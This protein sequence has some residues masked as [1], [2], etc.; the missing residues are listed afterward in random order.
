MSEATESGMVQMTIDGKVGQFPAGMTILEAA[1]NLGIDIPTLCYSEAV[2]QYGACRLCTVELIRRGKSR[3]VIACMHPVG[4][5]EVKTDSTSVR[6]ARRTLVEFFLARSPNSPE[7]K[8]LHRRFGGDGTPPYSVAA[9][10]GETKC[11][12]CGLCVRVCSE[13]IGA[14]AVGFAKR[15]M[16][17]M[18]AA[19]LMEWSETCIGCGTCVYVCPTNAIKVADI[20]SVPTGH[21]WGHEHDHRQCRTCASIDARP[22]FFADLEALTLKPEGGTT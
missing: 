14:S 11:V 21:E 6:E 16:A 3:F 20:N 12:L 19:G 17:K 18:V 4:P 2:S 7:L 22:E 10:F 13:V 1:R 15:G 8:E 9:D 5:F